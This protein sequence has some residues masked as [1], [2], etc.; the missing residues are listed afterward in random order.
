MQLINSIQS[1]WLKTKRSAASWL[2]LIGGTFIPVIF[3]IGMIKDQHTIDMH[4]GVSNAWTYFFF[5]VW[6]YMQVFILP[7]GLILATSLITQVEYRNNTWKI[8]HTAPQSY[9]HVFAA[10]FIVLLGMTGLFF[11]YFNATWLLAGIAPSLIF[12]GHFP[13]VEFPWEQF[14]SSNWKILLTCLPVLSLQF[15]LSLHFRNFLVSIGA[16]LLLLIASL[17][18]AGQWEYAYVIPYTYSSYSVMGDPVFLE[19]IHMYAWSVGYFVLFLSG[20]YVLYNT[21]RAKG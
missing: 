11:I 13:P 17:I 2:C 8:V 1:E 3:L 21:N 6:Q 14:F 4:E 7:M 18:L 15:L 19:K 20:S 5:Q 12:D 16:G 10:K 9:L